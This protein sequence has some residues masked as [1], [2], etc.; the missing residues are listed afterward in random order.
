MVNLNSL[1]RC[2][3]LLNSGTT[4]LCV[5]VTK[6]KNNSGPICTAAEHS[7]MALRLQFF[8]WW[9]P[10]TRPQLPPGSTR[11]THSIHTPGQRCQARYW[12]IIEDSWKRQHH[13]W[14]M[15]HE[16]TRSCGETPHVNK[17]N[18][19]VRYYYRHL[20]GSSQNVRARAK[21]K[22]LLLSGLLSAMVIFIT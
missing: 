16:D 11:T 10:A 6:V 5:V 8:T 17:G 22:C 15:V 20:I 1:Q 18:G 13:H 14:H 3:Y 2:S 19:Q 4:R 7:D 9:K 21:T 12:C